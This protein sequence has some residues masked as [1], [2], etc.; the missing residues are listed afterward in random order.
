MELRDRAAQLSLSWTVR[1]AFSCGRRAAGTWGAPLRYLWARVEVAGWGG[2]TWGP[3]AS[4]WGLCLKEC[5]ERQQLAVT[6]ILTQFTLLGL[7]F[8]YAYCIRFVFRVTC[9]SV[10]VKKNAMKKSRITVHYQSR[11]DA[12]TAHS[13]CARYSDR[14]LH[15]FFNPEHHPENS[16]VTD[17][18]A[19]PR[20]FKCLESGWAEFSAQFSLIPCLCSIFFCTVCVMLRK[21]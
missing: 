6:S 10:F 14:Y 13:L 4:F 19:E 8:Q 20:R 3:P 21:A 11:K 5:L 15:I 16:H 9:T 17:K 18:R 2:K 12:N 1:A 7:S